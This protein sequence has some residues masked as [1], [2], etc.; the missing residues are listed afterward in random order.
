MAWE[1][2][3]AGGALPRHPPLP[4]SPQFPTHPPRLP[5]RP[6]LCAARLRLLFRAV[7]RSAR[8]APGN[9]LP[10]SRG[11]SRPE[12]SGA[13]LRSRRNRR[14]ANATT[15]RRSTTMKSPRCGRTGGARA[16]A[17]VFLLLQRPGSRR[18]RASCCS[19]RSHGNGFGGGFRFAHRS[20]DA[21]RGHARGRDIGGGGGRRAGLRRP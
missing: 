20:I 10:M 13:N 5:Q 1:R 4:G 19:R 16:P 14:A 11:R 17:A 21:L 7:R 2:T 6:L 18:S 8:L 12:R 3:A 15:S 9:I